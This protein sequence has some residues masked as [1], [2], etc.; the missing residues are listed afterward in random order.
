M[1]LEFYLHRG[2]DFYFS[3]KLIPLVFFSKLIF[4]HI[5]LHFFKESEYQIAAV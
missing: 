4:V 1:L 2:F 5:F 3:S